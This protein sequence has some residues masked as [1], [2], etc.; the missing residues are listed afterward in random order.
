MVFI[1]S[2]KLKKSRNKFA[3]KECKSAKEIAAN[4]TNDTN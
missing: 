1:A 3:F 2:G 4:Y